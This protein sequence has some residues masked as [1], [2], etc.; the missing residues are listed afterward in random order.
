M[1]R[2]LLTTLSLLALAGLL[3][4]TAAA[5]SLGE[6]ARQQRAKKGPAPAEVKEYTNDNLPTSS[7]LSTSS[8][9]SATTPDSASASAGADT[10][11]GDASSQEER[12]KA[13][14]EWRDKFAEQKNVIATLERELDVATRE[15]NNRQGQ[16]Q[17]NT[18]DVGA[19]LRNPVLIAS[20]NQKYQD[21]I[22]GKK[23]D[24]E[25]AKQKLEDMKDDLRKAGL[26]STWAN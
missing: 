1:K 4:A 8:A 12:A 7:G 3:T 11:K 10:S 26:P 14:K 17:Y 16:M 24:L 25:A 20:E 15:N 6:Y 9:S 21:E 23:K 2:T 22:N 18:Y 5:Q 13:E 19:R